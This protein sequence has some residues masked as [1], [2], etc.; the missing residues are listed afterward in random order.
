MDSGLAGTGVDEPVKLKEED[1]NRPRNFHHKWFLHKIVCDV[2][3]IF[4]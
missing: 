1:L 3:D 4:Y 2:V